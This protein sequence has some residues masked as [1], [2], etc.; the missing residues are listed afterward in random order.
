MTALAIHSSAA[1]LGRHVTQVIGLGV[2]RAYRACC[3]V[4]PRPLVTPVSPR[5]SRPLGG[6]CPQHSGT[7]ESSFTIFHRLGHERDLL[8]EFDH[9]FVPSPSWQSAYI[10]ADPPT[11]PARRPATGHRGQ[12]EECAIRQVA[13][14]EVT[15]RLT[16]AIEDLDQAVQVALAEG[17]RGVVCDLSAVLKGAEP[18]AVEMLATAGR[19]VRDWPGTP[20][21]VACPDPQVREALRVHP[22]GGHLIV[23]ESMFSAVSAVLATPTLVVERLRL[24]AH[25]T[26]P[27]ASRE[28]VTRTLRDWHLDAISPFASLVV[29][30]LVANSSVGAGTDID[31]SVTW[32]LGALRLTVRDHGPALPGQRPPAPDLQGRRFAA[33]VEGRSRTFGALPSADGGKV[34][35][36][37]LEA[38][39][40]PRCAK[41]Q[42]PHPK[43]GLEKQP[44][45]V[46]DRLAPSATYSRT[47]PT[48]RDGSSQNVTVTSD[49]ING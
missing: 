25:A 24:A 4:L 6:P 36:A 8:P 30:E 26:A 43:A 22:V 41:Q 11:R 33:V 12:L 44:R 31:L 15:G 42:D 7:T 29:S 16:D 5:Y 32:N 13:V 2:Y 37:V 14:L 39:R 38:Q 19:H 18:G 20:V 10:S 49:Q 3:C 23:T 21:A 35:W 46:A 40:Q 1:V 48:N 45:R 17:P 9:H 27:R 47:L 34:V 28:F